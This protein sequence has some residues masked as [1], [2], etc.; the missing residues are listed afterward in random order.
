[1]RRFVLA[2][3]E[4]LWQIDATHWQLADGR[5]RSRSSTSS[6]TTHGCVLASRRRGHAAPAPHAWETFTQAGS[7]RGGCRPG[8]CRTTGLTFN[9]SRRQANRAR[10][11]RTCAPP[12]SCPITSTPGHPQTCGKVERFHQTLKEWLSNQPASNDHRRT[13]E[14]SSTPFVEHYNHHRP[15]R[16]LGGATPAAVWARATRRAVPADHPITDT[17]HHRPAT[18]SSPPRRHVRIDGHTSQRRR[19]LRRTH[20][21]RD[22][23]RHRLRHLPRQPT[24]PSPQHQPRPIQPTHR[25]HHEAAPDATTPERLMTHLSAMSRDI[26]VRPLS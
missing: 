3:P 8:C 18:S 22:H 17:T 9:G 23:H 24:R 19:H 10:S 13:P 20:R 16:A 4:R 2:A 15:H 1:M 7:Q 6:M 14:P 5:P 12:G 11:K 25:Q 26:P 21:H